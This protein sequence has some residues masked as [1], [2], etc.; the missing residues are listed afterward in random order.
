LANA[1]KK[2]WMTSDIKRIFRTAWE[3]VARLGQKKLPFIIADDQTRRSWARAVK[4]YDSVPENYK[5]FFDALPPGE[6]NPFPYTVITPTFRGFIKPE[7]EKLICNPGGRI[8]VLERIGNKLTSTC[9]PLE[10]IF[11]V[12]A[13]KIL[14]YSW[15]T[16]HGVD[17]NGVPTS[18]TIKSSLVTDYLITPVVESI[19]PATILAK[20]TDLGTEIAHFDCLGR[21][22]FKFMSYAKK[23]IRSGE[24]VIQ[25]ILQPEIRAEVLKLFDKTFSRS[26]STAHLIILTD[27]ELIII[28]DDESQ[29]W[30]KGS[31]HG[32][33]WSYIPLNKVTSVSLT[34]K[35][36]DLLVLSILL[37]EKQHLDSL[38]QVSMKGE[39]ERL[40]NRFKSY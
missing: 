10:D 14:L 3:L 23:S 22:N 19:R 37:S 12:E 18:S 31:R 4:S 27:S 29:S 34:G 40:V 20:D 25:T 6:R 32:G 30:L 15:I 13:G 1:E 28:R 33:I 7:N 21:L 9:Y 2:N 5:G 11:Y 8:Y 17:S 39:L 35:D 26:I 38:F 36:N 16:I 24:K